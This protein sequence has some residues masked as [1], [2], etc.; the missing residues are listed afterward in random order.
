MH[1]LNLTHKL[2]PC[3]DKILFP[4][5]AGCGC[6]YEST[7]EIFDII[8]LANMGLHAEVGLSFFLGLEVNQ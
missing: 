6:F 3:L 1:I 8:N 4:K 2:K 7:G 5:R